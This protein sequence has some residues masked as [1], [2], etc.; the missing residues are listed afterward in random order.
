MH[1]FTK[2]EHSLLKGYF[3]IK[4]GHDIPKFNVKKGDL[5]GFVE[6]NSQRTEVSP[7]QLACDEFSYQLLQHPVFSCPPIRHQIGVK[8]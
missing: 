2:T 5:G 7:P 6:N 4:S 3:Q 1:T 8:R